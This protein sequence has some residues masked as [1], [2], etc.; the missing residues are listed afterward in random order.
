MHTPHNGDAWVTVR[1]ASALLHVSTW[2]VYRWI[3]DGK[4][5]SAQ[6]GR[7]HL[8]LRSDVDALLSVRH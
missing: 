5:R 1:E 3:E 8:V 6:P 7:R 2:T 4:L